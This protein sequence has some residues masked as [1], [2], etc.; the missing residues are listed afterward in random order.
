MKFIVTKQ[1]LLDGLQR[2][3]N[4]ISNRV[5][6]PILSN[7]L[8]EVSEKGLSLTA[9]DL[10][11]SIRTQVSVAMLEKSGSTTLP[12]RRLLSIIRELPA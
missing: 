8:L 3:Q 1:A 10:E 7:V 5:T 2:I 11:V 9:T 4:I 6:L 12:A